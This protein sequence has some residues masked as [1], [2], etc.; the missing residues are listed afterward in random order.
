MNEQQKKIIWGSNTLFH[1]LR[2]KS[3]GPYRS[4]DLV[5]LVVVVWSSHSALLLLALMFRTDIETRQRLIPIASGSTFPSDI[6]VIFFQIQAY[7]RYFRTLSMNNNKSLCVSVPFWSHLTSFKP[8][9]IY[10]QASPRLSFFSSWE[11]WTKSISNLFTDEIRD[12]LELTR[13]SLHRQNPLCFSTLYWAV[14]P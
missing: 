11:Q 14:G 8:V 10:V 4:M 1:L 9:Y 7:Y 2:D 6:L 5:F 13:F 12:S 3:L